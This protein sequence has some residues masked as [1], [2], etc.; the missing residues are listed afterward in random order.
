M[1]PILLALFGLDVVGVVIRMYAMRDRAVSGKFKAISAGIMLGAA[2]FWIFPDLME[3]SGCCPRGLNHR[4]WAR[5]G[6]RH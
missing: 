6:V 4:G 3:K 5:G 1:Y 2:L